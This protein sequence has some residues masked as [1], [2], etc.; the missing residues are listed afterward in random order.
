MQQAYH[1]K[2]ALTTEARAELQWWAQEASIQN[3]TPVVAHLPD[4]IIETEA[5]L[6]GWGALHQGCWT[7]GQWSAEE[8]QMHINALELLAVSCTEDF[9]Q[10]QITFECASSNGQ[11]VS[12][13]VHKPFGGHTLPSAELT[14]GPYVEMVPGLPHFSYSRTPARQGE[15]DSRRGIQVVRDRCNWMILPNLFLRYRK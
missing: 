14:G 2:I 9:S 15:L 13:S 1:W 8:K 10:R 11:H 3:Q 5:S 7:G 6:V 4:M 12:Q